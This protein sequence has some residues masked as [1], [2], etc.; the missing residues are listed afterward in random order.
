MKIADSID[1]IQQMVHACKNNHQTIALVPTMGNLHQGHLSLIDEAKKHANQVIVSIFV[2]PLQF[3][4]HA[5]LASYPRTLEDDLEKLQLKKIDAVFLPHN[6]MI[7]PEGMENH[8]TI[9]VPVFSDILCGQNRPG[10]F[11]GVAT[12]VN[13]LFNLIQP[14]AAVFGQKDFQQLAIIKKM[15]AD[16]ALNVTIIDVPTVREPDGL[17]MSSRNT[18]LTDEE[19]STAACMYKIMLKTSNKI[20]AGERD[21]K[22]LERN[23]IDQLKA[24]NFKPEYFEIR[25]RERLKKARAEDRK[26]IIFCASYLGKPRLIDNICF[27]I[28]YKKPGGRNESSTNHKKISKPQTV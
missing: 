27:D 9:E 18:R 11:R 2:N 14:D 26:L 5:D 21:F 6:K 10:H 24:L 28:E 19:R 22:L 12:I 8:T 16:L 17:A 4:N 7:Y 1:C 23:A 3:N 15:V 20:I 13:K 25:E